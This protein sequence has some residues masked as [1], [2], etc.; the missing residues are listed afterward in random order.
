[1]ATTVFV[2]DNAAIYL[3][4]SRCGTPVIKA[5]ARRPQAV[6]LS[7]CRSVCCRRPQ[8]VRLSVCRSFCCRRPQAVRP[9]VCRSV[10][11]PRPQAVRLS[12]C[13]SVCCPR[14]QAVRLSVCRSVCCP[15][16][17]AVRLSV[18]VSAAHD[19]RLPSP[20]TPPTPPP[21]SRRPLGHRTAPCRRWRWLGCST[22]C[23]PTTTAGSG[24]ASEVGR[25]A[26]RAGPT[27]S[28]GSY[29]KPLFAMETPSSTL[30]CI[31]G[32]SI[33]IYCA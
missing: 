28:Y 29:P 27:T 1:M 4:S 32:G 30:A 17:Q 33:I 10:C 3:P 25:P 20:P 21:S 12:V 19:P 11:C 16:P 31:R 13:R 2:N 23:S 7:V 5:D 26:R 14:P 22:N 9:S 24:P 8:A 15:R 18:A 6:R